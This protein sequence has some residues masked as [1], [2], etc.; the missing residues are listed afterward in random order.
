MQKNIE[1]MTRLSAYLTKGLL[2]AS[3]LIAAGIAATILFV[4]DAFYA[5]YG[6]DTRSDVSLS[7][8]LKAPAGMLL[9]AGL[10]MLA[11]VV[12][13][14]LTLTSLGTAS[15]IY[16][17]YGLSRLLSM[18]IDGIPHNALVHA[19]ML[20]ITIGVISLL[21]FAR[22]RKSKSAFSAR[23]VARDAWDTPTEEV[24]R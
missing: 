6:I 22:Y 3:G 17:S 18:A 7:N 9:L 15:L 19:A 5:S 10:L 23:I 20:E 1:N 4:P 24:A 2:L 11:G 21:V 16:L 14:E 13:T 12:R 8:E